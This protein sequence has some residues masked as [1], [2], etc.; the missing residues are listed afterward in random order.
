MRILVWIVLAFGISAS[1]AQTT[2]NQDSLK[3]WYLKDKATE[4]FAGISLN[5]AYQFLQGR[6]STPIIVAVIDSGIDTLHEDLKPILWTNPKEI[7]GNG[8]DDDGNGYVDDVHGWN[9][10]GGKDGTEA[11]KASSEKARVYHG[12]KNLY[13]GKNIDTNKLSKDELWQ[14]KM[15]KRSAAQIEPNPETADEIKGLTRYMQKMDECDSIITKETG[16]R[17]FSADE[18]EKLSLTSIEGKQAKMIHLNLLK[19]L[20]SGA[21]AKTSLIKQLLNEQLSHLQDEVQEKT[22]APVDVHATIIKDNYKDFNDRYYGNTNIMGKGSMHGTHVSGIIA[23]ARNNGVG[24]DG[25]ADNVKI[26]MIRAVP[27]G[28]EYDKDIALAIRYAVDN[29]AKVINMSFGK[30]YSPQKK[31]V[32]EAFQYAASKDVLLVHAAGNDGKNIDST[33]NYPS[34][35]FL[36][37]GHASNVITV[38]ASSDAALTG[39]YVAG[40]SNYGKNGTDV[41]APG[42]QIYSSLPGGNAYGFLDGTSMATPV[43]AGLAALVRSYF[44]KLSAVQT[45]E[46]IE[47]SISKLDSTASVYMPGTQMLVNMSALCHSGGLINAYGAVT[48]ADILSKGPGKDKKVKLP[49]TTFKNTK[50]KA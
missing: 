13:L 16:M 44:P 6:K 9:F 26:M 5:K 3:G 22:T 50:V 47:L 1:F 8:I 49:K 32:D 19:M 30:S 36:S 7:P 48:E 23:A 31:W 20:S 42:V 37:G 11:E 12:F 45:K 21:D 39:S 35:D 15:W 14:Y 41:F 29:G 18:L 17:D 34:A 28:D 10:L 46:A 27:D 33:E 24:M 25:I 38:G 4:G 2:P 40:F 43:V